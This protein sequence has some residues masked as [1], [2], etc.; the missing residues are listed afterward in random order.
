MIQK[1]IGYSYNDLTIVPAVFSCVEHRSECNPFYK[2]GMLPLF[3]APMSCIVDET[4]FELWEA[5]KINAI[6][7]RTVKYE[8]RMKFLSDSKWTA[9]SLDEFKKLF[10]EDNKDIEAS[11]GHF[12]VCI[13]LAN[14]HMKKLYDLIKTAKM[15]M[16]KFNYVLE[17]MTGNIA[18]FRTYENIVRWRIPVD[19]IRLSIGSGNGCLTSSNTGVHYPIASLIDQCRIVKSQA[20]YQHTFYPKIIADGGIR[21]F[22]DI[23]IALALG[24]DYVMIGSVFAGIIES[25]AKL[26]YER[27][28]D[29]NEAQW[30]E[31]EYMK[32]HGNDQSYPI[33]VDRVL[34]AM[35]ARCE[36][37]L[38]KKFYGMSTR[39]AQEEINAALESPKQNLE[40]KT[41]EGVAK[42]VKCQYTMKQWTE[43]FIDYLRS[44]MSYTNAKTVEEFVKNTELVINSPKAIDSVNK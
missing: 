32:N 15:K 30:I 14:G 19:Y 44:A 18:N 24:A 1:E 38:S 5:N 31:V 29:R 39:Q 36:G 21:N 41:S 12:K 7:P 27:G 26:Y 6:I 13:D 4:N 20:Q 22:N 40:K 3:T 28:V 42:Y 8:T 2:D 23:N 17:I 10:V 35:I 25:S 34:R 11:T 37:R 9:F 33:E 43:N 16:Q